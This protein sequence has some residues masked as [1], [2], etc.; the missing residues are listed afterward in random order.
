[1]RR[2]LLV[3][4]AAAGLL[5]ALQPPGAGAASSCDISG[6]E[7]VV[8]I[9]D[10]HG[11]YDR[12][13]EILRATG[14]VDAELQW[15]GGKTHLVQL[16]DVVDR[17]PD[18]RKALDLLPRL[19]GQAVRA[20]GRVH[21]LLGNHEVMRMLGDMRYV[22]PGEYQAF[23]T[24]DS[25]SLR[26][27]FLNTAKADLRADLRGRTPFGWVEMRLAFGR[28]GAYGKRLQALDTVV[29]IGG[30]VFVHGGISP[31]VATLSCTAINETVR[32]EMTTDFEK[33]A[34]DPLRSLSAR[35]DGPLWY[36]G[37]ALEPESFTPEL[38]QIL[39]KQ[40]AHTI[41]VAHT[42][43][44]TWRIAARF[45]GRVVQLDTGMQPAYVTGGRASALE[46]KGGVFTA[47]YLDSQE[48]LG[49]PPQ[50]QP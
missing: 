40:G 46:Y 35:E 6:V 31:S 19:A 49:N 41:V 20:G 50:S 36:R 5:A 32:R 42:V 43:T 27:R 34:S 17:G 28:D 38:D 13:T 24:A 21:Q 22:T 9:G 11:A 37:L 29:K 10:I 25:E 2:R 18:S 26:E 44:P 45:G 8:A 12:L 23:A 15:T 3:F 48:P 16:G 30:V 14:L 39:A 47:I 7:R 33:T 1:M 4:A